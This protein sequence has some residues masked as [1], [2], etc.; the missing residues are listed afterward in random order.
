MSHSTVFEKMNSLT[1]KELKHAADSVDIYCSGES[2]KPETTCL[3]AYHT[4]PLIQ[5]SHETLEVIAVLPINGGFE[6]PLLEAARNTLK[7]EY[8]CRLN[9]IRK[10]IIF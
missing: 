3:L 2:F 6:K 4:V 1:F 8:E 5:R 7:H 9:H 10:Q